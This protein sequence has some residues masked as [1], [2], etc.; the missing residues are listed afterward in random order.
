MVLFLLAVTTNFAQEL[1]MDI[2]DVHEADV[3]NPKFNSGGLEKFYDFI[4][5]QFDY[6]KVTKPGKLVT[7]FTI[8]ALGE[9]KNI[10]ILK[11]PN[12]KAAAEI[13]R[14]LQKAHKWEPAKRAG[15]PFPIEINFPLDFKTK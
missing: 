5:Q 4:D 9:I 12:D 6:S 7:S 14:V 3:I 8:N 10:R 13:I 2:E 15:K 1:F 11:F